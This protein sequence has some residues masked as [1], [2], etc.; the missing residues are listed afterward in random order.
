MNNR[1]CNAYKCL[2][3]SKNFNLMTF[4]KGPIPYIPLNN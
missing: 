4:D 2:A 1:Y 3:K